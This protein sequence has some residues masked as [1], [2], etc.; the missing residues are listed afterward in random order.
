MFGLLVRFTCKDEGS[1]EAFDLLVAETLELIKGREPGT[2][3]Y[4]S[5]RVEGEPLVRVFYELYADRDAFD[6][7]E[8]QEHVKRFLAARE[9]FLTS[10][11]VDWLS[12]DDGKGI[13]I[14]TG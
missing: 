10:V 13:P 12:T 5:H 11:H 4:V 8:E 3:V 7:H 6:A 1:A 2:L 14:R 9:A